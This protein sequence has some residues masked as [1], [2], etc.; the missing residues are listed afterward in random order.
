MAWWCWLQA[1][2]NAYALAHNL[3]L[4][5]LHGES[6]SPYALLNQLTLEMLAG[7]FVSPCVELAVICDCSALVVEACS[8]QA[9]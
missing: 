1:A 9:V 6:P 2:A 4:E 5:E 3:E 8:L 7:A